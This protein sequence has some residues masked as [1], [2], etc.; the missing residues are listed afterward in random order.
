M[1][2]LESSVS[3]MIEWLKS[4]LRPSADQEFVTLI[5]VALEDEQVGRHL[6]QIL[7]L[8]D[9]QREQTLIRWQQ[10]LEV[11]GAPDAMLRMLTL[12]RDHKLAARAHQILQQNS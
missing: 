7:S 8:P 10:A 9:A 11:Q 4:R 5:Q 3:E 1:T 6:R 12:L 2:R